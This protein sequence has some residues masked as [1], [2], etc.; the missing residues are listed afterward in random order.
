MSAFVAKLK[1]GGN[2]LWLNEGLLKTLNYL[3]LL[4]Q[5]IVVDYCCDLSKQKSDLKQ[6]VLTI[7]YHDYKY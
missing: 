7:F 4:L 2:V 3:C 6:N 5:V 1:G